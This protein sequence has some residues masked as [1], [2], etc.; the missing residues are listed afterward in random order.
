MNKYVRIVISTITLVAAGCFFGFAT[1]R[2]VHANDI[3]FF[4]VFQYFKPQSFGGRITNTNTPPNV[5]CVTDSASPFY[6]QMAKGSSGGSGPWSALQP[7][8]VG[9]V[10]ANAYILG[11]LA[12]GTGSCVTDSTP[13]VAYPTSTTNYYGTSS[14]PSYQQ[15][16]CPD[17]FDLPFC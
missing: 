13:P 14:S 10:N 5:T 12:Y 17:N 16:N 7:P 8:V 4:S 2:Q 3:P 1:P 9:T 6:I 15:F 11:L